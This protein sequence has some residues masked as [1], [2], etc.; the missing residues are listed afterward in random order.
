MYP[1]PFVP[2]THKEPKKKR[3]HL[4]RSSTVDQ[5][6]DP[7][8]YLASVGRSI[9]VSDALDRPMF[10]LL[11][12]EDFC[13]QTTLAEWRER[14]PSRRQRAACAAWRAEGVEIAQKKARIR[15]LAAELGLIADSEQR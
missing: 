14:R 10:G 9:N 5:E 12:T 1:D 7:G 13:W 6:P 11:M 4:R 2:K 15:D 8:L 3:G